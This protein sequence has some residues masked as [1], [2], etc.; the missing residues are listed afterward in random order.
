[1]RGFVLLIITL[2]T[3]SADKLARA[4]DEL[5]FNRDIRPILSD[6]CFFCHGPDAEHREADLRLDI[7]EF[8]KQDAIEPGNASTSELISRIT[9]SDPDELMP[10]PTAICGSLPN[11]LEELDGIDGRRMV[12]PRSVRFDKCGQYCVD[13][14]ERIERRKRQRKG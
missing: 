14:E 9:S 11:P 13:R 4:D 7:E 8:A 1:M 6:T 12:P 5:S 2:V 3:F 10:H